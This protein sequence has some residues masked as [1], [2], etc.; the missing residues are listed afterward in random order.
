MVE[1]KPRSFEFSTVA[2]SLLGV[3]VNVLQSHWP[4]TAIC[5]RQRGQEI[6]KD[7][8][9]VAAPPI[10]A[11][12][13]VCAV[14][15]IPSV[16]AT[17]PISANKLAWLA[18]SQAA[19]HLNSGGSI[20][21]KRCVALQDHEVSDVHCVFRAVCSPCTASGTCLIEAELLSDQTK[22]KRCLK[23][24]KLFVP[25]VYVHADHTSAGPANVWAAWLGTAA[26]VHSA[27]RK[28]L[29]SARSAPHTR[30]DL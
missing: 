5:A 27:S 30:R 20:T 2:D 19:C 13:T 22:A 18:L 21:P 9:R 14:R 25:R 10:C 26:H 1:R 24:T 28:A 3:S 11:V 17:Q 15:L 29:Q 6:R 4:T 7:W 12:V 16:L 8:P 23:L